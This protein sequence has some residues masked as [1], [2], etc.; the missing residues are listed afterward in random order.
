MTFK[1]GQLCKRCVRSSSSKPYPRTPDHP[2]WIKHKLTDE[3]WQDWRNEN[4]EEV[5]RLQKEIDDYGVSD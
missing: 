5:K 1:R 2:T 4:H 3:S